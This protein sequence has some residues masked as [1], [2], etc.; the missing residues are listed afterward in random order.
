MFKDRLDAARQLATAL[1]HYKGQHPLVLAIPRGA[2]PMAVV[3]AQQLGADMDVVLVR[4][5]RAPFMPEVAIG[6]TD[7]NGKTYLAAHAQEM[8][9]DWDY[10]QEEKKTQLAVLQRRRQQYNA[11]RQPL[12]IAARTVIVMDDGL[13]TGATM[14]AALQVLRQ[15][16][17]ARLICAVPVASPD[18]LEKVRPWADELVCLSAPEDFQGVG[19]FYRD[20][21]QVEDED[22]LACLRSAAGP[23]TTH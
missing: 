14:I 19:Q 15:H 11:I 5:L 20:F 10:L 23:Q 21:Q 7:E 2:V 6:A 4:K 3:T 12:P 17:P 8:G 22:V 1:S 18:A 9:A 13:A 16:H